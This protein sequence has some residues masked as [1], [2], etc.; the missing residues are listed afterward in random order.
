MFGE[1]A[2]VSGI[3]VVISTSDG[4]WGVLGAIPTRGAVVHE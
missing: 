1:P 2:M 4:P 3:S